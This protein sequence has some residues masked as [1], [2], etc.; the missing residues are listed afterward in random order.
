[1]TQEEMTDFVFNLV[2]W[3][4]IILVVVAIWAAVEMFV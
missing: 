1:M 3:A 4:K 2:V